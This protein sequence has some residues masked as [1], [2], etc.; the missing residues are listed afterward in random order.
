MSTA[1]TSALGGG[2][3]PMFQDWSV[4]SNYIVER[5]LGTGSYGSVCRAIQVSTGHK[6]AIKR[7]KNV[8]EDEIDCKR[9]LREVTL[10][11]KL[12]HP[13]VVK[14]IE[15]LE[16]EDMSNFQQLYIVMEYMQSDLKKL[17]RS[18]LFLETFHI[19][20]IMY[21]LCLA[22]KY[23]HDSQVLHRDIKPANILINEDC[24]IKICD[25]GLARSI[26][27][28]AATLEAEH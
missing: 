12:N 11:R 8:F 18:S 27:T 14:I 25:F 13:S 19:Q 24:S 2:S 21:N 15:I 20:K 17:I 26:W 23:L 9:I 10:M 7:I 3:S 6:V 16:P 4:G 1:A 5:V 28:S 22:V